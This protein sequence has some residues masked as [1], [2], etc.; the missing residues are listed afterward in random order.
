MQVE[1][2]LWY[3]REDIGINLH[4]WHWHLVYPFSG[5][6]EIVN[7]DRRGELFYYMHQQIIARYNAERLCNNLQRVKRFNNFREPIKEAYFPKLNSAVA[8][9][10]WPSRT[11]KKHLSDISRDHFNLDVN[12]LERWYN[13]IQ[14]AIS[15]GFIEQTGKPGEDTK[16]ALNIDILGNI[17]EAS[18]LSPNP[19]L[20]GDLH[21]MGHNFISF[22]HDPDNQYLENFG[23]MGTPV[24]GHFLAVFFSLHLKHCRKRRCVIRYSTAGTV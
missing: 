12:D 20:Y 16:R 22:V 15:K 2:R 17:V 21:N 6:N 19:R 4:H 13:S 11:S 3:F 10:E 14:N 24:S 23:V 8:S 18:Q 1:H 7:K 9:R 5:L